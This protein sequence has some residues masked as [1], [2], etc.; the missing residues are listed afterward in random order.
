MNTN[1]ARKW[2][3]STV[4]TPNEKRKVA[5]RVHKQGWITK[6][7]KILYALLGIG[8][9]A[10]SLY[11]V[12]Y[13]STTDTLNRDIQSLETKIQD[14]QIKIEALTFEKKELSQPERIIRI[15]RDN[16][17]KIPETE[18]KQAQAMNNN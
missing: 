16:G 5:V 11:I 9:I 6:G 4:A 17:L 3:Y 18:V 1:H 7:E 12:S 10:V 14:Q 8:L 13:T 2:D 15:A